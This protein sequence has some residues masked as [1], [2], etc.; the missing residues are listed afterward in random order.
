VNCKWVGTHQLCGAVKNRT[1]RTMS[2][3]PNLGHW[4]AIGTCNVWN[5]SGLPVESWWDRAQCDQKALG[6][7][8]AGGNGTWTDVDAFTFNGHG[9]H[10]RFS[11]VG[12]WHWR[13]KGVWTKIPDGTVADCV[14]GDNNQVWCTILGQI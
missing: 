5:R 12:K 3:T 7:G 1:S 9:Y 14:I 10:E 2:Y 6:K 11:R 4:K 8:S 13:A